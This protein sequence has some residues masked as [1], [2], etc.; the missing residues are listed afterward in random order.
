MG[1][2]AVEELPG[3]AVVASATGSAVEELPG[4]AGAWRPSRNGAPDREN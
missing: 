2:A 3:A 4:A 1:L